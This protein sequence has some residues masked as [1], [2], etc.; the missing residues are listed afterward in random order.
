MTKFAKILFSVA[1]III[2]LFIG[3]FYSVK[4]K[5]VV[6]DI[7]VV[8]IPVEVSSI[9]GCYVSKLAKDIYVLNIQSENN[10][11]VSGMLAYNNY[12]KDSSSGSFS[13]T[14]SN[15]ILLGNYSFDSEGMRS[16][17]QVIFNR[18]EGNFIQ[19]FG[20]AKTVDDKEVFENLSAVTYDPK[21]V[22]V[23]SDDCSIS[24]KDSNNIFT[25][26]YNS[27]WKI[28][29]GEKIPTIDWSTNTQDKGLVLAR[30][31][32]QKTYM[33][34]TNFSDAKFTVG[35]STDVKAIKS[36]LTPVLSNEVVKS[37]GEVKISGYSFK[38]ST[39]REGAAGN[40]YETTNYR[41]IVDGDCYAIGYTIH[42]T[43][44]GNYSPDQGI[45]EFDRTKIVSEL[46]K[47]VKSFKFIINSD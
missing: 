47:I 30:V 22:F 2:L 40:F 25:F 46:E 20:P 10:G 45:K 33:P 14:F 21:L 38:K 28:M 18:V 29:E 35:R 44:I 43:N 7:V 31:L 16:N 27:F 42:S 3:V 9:K 1:I 17:R 5:K 19:G 32:V 13:G 41:G 34:G 8:P 24:F 4:D 11:M 39:S 36:C 6:E 37:D 23:K 15:N 26:D 12:Q